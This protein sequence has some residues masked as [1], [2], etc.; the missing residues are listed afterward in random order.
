VPDGAGGR[1]T[2]PGRPWHFS[3]NTKPNE[4]T[5]A[6]ETV[7]TGPE[8]DRQPARQGEHNEEVLRELG[9]CDDEISD[10]TNTGV[11]VHTRDTN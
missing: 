10:F 5:D 9:Y 6:A 1:I 2:V 11:L 3:G 7:D 4:S 8:P